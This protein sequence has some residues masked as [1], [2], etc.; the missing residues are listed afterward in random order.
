MLEKILTIEPIESITLYRL[1]ELYVAYFIIAAIPLII[2]IIIF[3]DKIKKEKDEDPI[4][5]GE[6]FVLVP[7]EDAIF[8]FF[9]IMLL[10]GIAGYIAHGIWAICHGF[11]AIIF[12]GIHGILSLRLWMGGLWLEAIA[13]HLFHDLVFV[14]CLKILDDK[15]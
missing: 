12:V 11:P 9:P 2:L 8:R 1:F 13:I 15:K 3:K 7:I 4:T 6:L 5:I 10:G 14:G